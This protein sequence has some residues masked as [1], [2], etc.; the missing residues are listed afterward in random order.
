VTRGWE[1]LHHELPGT[2]DPKPKS[3]CESLVDQNPEARSPEVPKFAEPS[4][5]RK[6]C[7]VKTFSHSRWFMNIV[8][9]LRV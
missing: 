1:S 2:E 6:L 5:L 4:E 3:E 9:L 8:I 7:E